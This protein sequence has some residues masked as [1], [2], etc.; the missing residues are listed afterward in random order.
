MRRE[1]TREERSAAHL[2]ARLSDMVQQA[3]QRFARRVP[4]CAAALHLVNGDCWV[5][6]AQNASDVLSTSGAY[7]Q[8]RLQAPAEGSAGRRD[9][10]CV[11]TKF[12]LHRVSSTPMALERTLASVRL[13]CRVPD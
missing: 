4:Q 13:R 7:E 11:A 5:V 2:G 9:I 3:Q 8:G 10:G 1:A 6:R 12:R